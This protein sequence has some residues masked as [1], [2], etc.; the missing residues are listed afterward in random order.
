MRKK[1][2][3]IHTYVYVV[4]MFL[5]GISYNSWLLSH[6]ASNYKNH[7]SSANIAFLLYWRHLAL[8]SRNANSFNWADESLV[9][10]PVSYRNSLVLNFFYCNLQ[11][12]CLSLLDICLSKLPVEDFLTNVKRFVVIFVNMIFACEFITILTIAKLYLNEV[13]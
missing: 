11:G 1:E 6:R 10:L 5:I 3:Y 8:L 13:A 2:R 12:I 9:P 4:I 7:S